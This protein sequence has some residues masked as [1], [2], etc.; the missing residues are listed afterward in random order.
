M[1]KQE[2]AMEELRELREHCLEEIA[3]FRREL[4]EAIEPAS[5]SDDDSADVA[6]DIYERSRIISLMQVQEAKV[7]A[8]ENAMDRAEKGV[9]GICERCGDEIVAER[10]SI[11]PETTFCVRCVSELE[12]GPLRGSVGGRRR[13]P[14]SRPLDDA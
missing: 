10:L 11:M 7:R 5:A 3:R 2:E 6:A 14:Q 4:K 9:Y 8:L 12:R 1:A 13:R